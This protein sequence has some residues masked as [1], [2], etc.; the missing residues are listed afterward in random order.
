MA[1]KTERRGDFALGDSTK[2]DEA[3]GSSAEASVLALME[4]G[5]ERLRRAMDV[6]PRSSTNRG[7]AQV[8]VPLELAPL[9][10]ASWFADA[11]FS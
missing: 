5:R 10:M 8:G 9:E 3:V 11:V 1:R 6:A 7:I 2:Q 4:H